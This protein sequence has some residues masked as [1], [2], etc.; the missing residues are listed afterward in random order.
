ME[1]AVCERDIRAGPQLQVHVALSGR[2]RLARVNNDPA[3]AVVALLP[4]EL[5]QH[6]E[7]LRAVRARDQ[8]HLCE[9]YVAP[10]VCSA[11]NAK[12]LVVA[13]RGAHHAKPPVVVNIAR[14]QTCARELAHQVCL[15]GRE[16]RAGVN[17]NRVFAVFRLKL[18]E[19]RNNQIKRLVPC[20]ALE[21]AVALDE[22]I[23]KAVGV[24][25]L[26]V[27]RDAL[28]AEAALVHRKVVARLEP[29][30]MVLLD[31]KIHAALHTA[32]RT[33]RGHDSVNDP[34]G[35]PAVVRLRRASADRTL[36]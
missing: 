22:R 10:G 11:V 27:S 13:C 29:D 8:Q 19:F 35:A 5:I 17:P 14:A 15:L 32:V 34:V 25:N 28:R 18:F 6:R 26:Q 31:Q 16:R 30:D 33:V 21:H 1:H 9:R 7:G 36:L 12:S 4:E 2:R 20:R 24:V 23:Q 3:P